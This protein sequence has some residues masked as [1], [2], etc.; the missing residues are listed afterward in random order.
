M[1]DI[2]GNC[3][4]GPAVKGVKAQEC[5]S[6]D[7]PVLAVLLGDVNVSVAK[8]VGHAGGFAVDGCEKVQLAPSHGNEDGRLAQPC[9]TH[10]GADRRTRHLVGIPRKSDTMDSSEHRAPVLRLHVDRRSDDGG[11]VA[12]GIDVDVVRDSRK[13][14]GLKELSGM[15]VSAPFFLLFEW[16]RYRSL[17]SSR[18]LVV[19]QKS[20]QGTVRLSGD[21]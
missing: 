20:G 9:G 8:H 16:R 19:Q 17:R 5:V 13:A 10:D 6:R 7:H 14:E 4:R 18:D 11:G 12:H 3:I 2:A 21:M 1:P 15:S